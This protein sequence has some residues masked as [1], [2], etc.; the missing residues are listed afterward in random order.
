LMMVPIPHPAVDSPHLQ[1]QAHLP[2][3]AHAQLI[4]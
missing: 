4:H 2:L 1:A 3:Q